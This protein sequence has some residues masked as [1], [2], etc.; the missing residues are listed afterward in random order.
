MIF[1]K[2]Y[3]ITSDNILFKDSNNYNFK[4]KFGHEI[5]TEPVNSSFV[6]FKFKNLSDYEG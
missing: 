6:S 5:L 1:Y 2:K 3:F 4:Y